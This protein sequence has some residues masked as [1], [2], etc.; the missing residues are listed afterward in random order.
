MP[1]LTLRSALLAK[2]ESAEGTNA[3]P[4]AVLDAIVTVGNP[5]VAVNPEELDRGISNPSLSKWGFVVGMKDQTVTFSTE[6]KGPGRSL[7]AA[8]P[9]REDPLFRACAMVPTYA[10]SSA[11]YNFG[12]SMASASVSATCTIY[13]WQDGICHIL[14]GCRGSF[15]LDLADGQYGKINWEFKGIYD[16]VP[17]GTAAGDIIDNALPSPT[18]DAISILPQPFMGATFQMHGYNSMAAQQLTL[19]VDNNV[20]RRESFVAAN[21]IAGMLITERSVTGT[22][23][24]E[25]V[26]RAT[27]DFF[28]KH[29]TGAQSM[30]TFLYG[31]AS[32][33]IWQQIQVKAPGTQYRVPK[34]GDRNG[35]RT[36]EID[37]MC[38]RSATTG[39]DEL[40]IIYLTPA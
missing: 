10:V 5:T 9:L 14:K 23:N 25:A 4:T 11:T 17:F 7:S 39:D 37:F 12:T 28:Y 19:K 22:I 27:H 35:I 16:S 1:F 2:L 3:L 29:Q 21:G 20:Q 6:L 15:D 31:A 32:P 8:S 33:T 38:A 36:F 40:Q 13:A 18:Y 34:Y 30:M 24:P 26:P